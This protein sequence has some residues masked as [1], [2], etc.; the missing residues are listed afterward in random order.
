MRVGLHPSLEQAPV[1]PTDK[2][3]AV[4][5]SE[6]IHTRLGELKAI[7]SSSQFSELQRIQLLHLEAEIHYNYG[8]PEGASECLRQAPDVPRLRDLMNR[9][10]NDFPYRFVESN[11]LDKQRVWV[12][13]GVA[14]YQHYVDGEIDKGIQLLQ[15]LLAA[16]HHWS[17]PGT[18]SRAHFFLAHCYRARREF[19]KAEDHFLQA[20]VEAKARLVRELT[21]KARS[22][23]EKELERLFSVSC[24][25]RIL[26][27]LAWVLVQQGRLARSRQ[28]LFS[29]G[30]LLEATGQ[31]SLKLM[32]RYLT[33]VT[34]R[35]LFDPLRNPAES[36]EALTELRACQTVYEA[37]QDR[38]GIRRCAQEIALAGLHTAEFGQGERTAALDSVKRSLNVLKAT[39]E[40]NAKRT[41][42]GRA[43]LDRLFTLSARLEMVE[44]RSI[45]AMD[46]VRKARELR[47]RVWSETEFPDEDA[48]RHHDQVGEGADLTLIEAAIAISDSSGNWAQIEDLIGPQKWSHW[49]QDPVV[50][51]EAVLRLATAGVRFR[52]PDVVG[53]CLRQWKRLSTSVENWYLKRLREKVDRLSGRVRQFDVAQDV[54]AWGVE[55]LETRLTSGLDELR[56]VYYAEAYRKFGGAEGK[57]AFAKSLGIHK[58]TFLKYYRLAEPESRPKE[59]WQR[60]RSGPTSRASKRGRKASL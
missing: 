19:G 23:H 6:Q 4:A 17:A 50:Q 55:N 53:T 35:R 40:A 14:F 15:E 20:Q 3:A 36:D 45:S 5:L 48:P 13:M 51:A 43:E 25:A 59:E 26:A 8:N 46:E 33:A 24:S 10:T 1:S 56:G 60:G 21:E 22:A 28:L 41:D 31:E 44:S 9:P 27:G 47:S 7:A 52:R 32:V 49:E 57:E 2:H 16:I 54:E 12:L 39:A 37:L 18:K 34:E 30:T 11:R 42:G 58:A 38:R 29:A